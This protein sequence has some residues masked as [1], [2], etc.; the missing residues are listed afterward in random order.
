MSSSDE[1]H[2]DHECDDCGKTHMSYTGQVEFYK[3]NKKTR[4]ILILIV[5]V[6]LVSIPLSLTVFD[7]VKEPS[8]LDSNI[9][10]KLFEQ[11]YDVVCFSDYGMQYCVV[12]DNNANHI[13]YNSER[14]VL[15]AKSQPCLNANIS[16]PDKTTDLFLVTDSSECVGSLEFPLL[17][18]WS[19][20]NR[21][22]AGENSYQIGKIDPTFWWEDLNSELQS[23]VDN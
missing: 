20:T 8:M 9:D 12:S 1:S 14:L 17:N 13:A 5:C 10:Y 11:G 21:L 22:V 18:G 19:W 4:N 23:M 7:F 16:T 6:S 2:P 3:K 15:Q